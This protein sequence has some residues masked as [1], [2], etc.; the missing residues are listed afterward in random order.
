[1]NNTMEHQV[2]QLLPE[3]VDIGATNNG[4][5]YLGVAKQY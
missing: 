4:V 5:L 2:T 3:T 1:M